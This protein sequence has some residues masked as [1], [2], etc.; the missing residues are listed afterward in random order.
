M[1]ATERRETIESLTKKTL[2]LLLPVTEKY[3]LWSAESNSSIFNFSG[4]KVI[5]K[6][7][8]K[9]RP[10]ENLWD[11]IWDIVHLNKQKRESLTTLKSSLIKLK[12]RLQCLV[13]NFLTAKDQLLDISKDISNLIRREALFIFQYKKTLKM[14]RWINEVQFLVK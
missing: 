9:K 1:S 2:Q 3:F 13:K 6:N 11:N 12:E 14:L 4:G 10:K 7:S 5:R 8:E